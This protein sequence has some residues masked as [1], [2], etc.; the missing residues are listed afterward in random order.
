MLLTVRYPEA[1]PDTAPSLSLSS[2]PDLRPH[3]YFNLSDDKAQLL[4]GVDASIEESI[5]MAMIFTLVSALKEAAEE[6]VQRR[7]DTAIKAHE[8]AILEAERRENAKFHGDPVTKESFMKWREGF[9]REMEE[10]RLREE[11]RAADMKKKNVKEVVKL[12][13]RELWE[14]GLAGKGDVED[15]VVDGVE[16]LKV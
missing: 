1:Y 8:E 4:K 10:S 15:D 5:G 6:L 16:N 7:R 11:D 9:M 3:P 13:G 2:P 12:T 14:R